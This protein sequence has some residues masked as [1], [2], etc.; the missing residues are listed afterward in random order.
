MGHELLFIHKC[1]S[2][3]SKFGFI[4]THHYEELQWIV[5]LDN[6]SIVIRKSHVER[7]I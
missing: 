3:V 4:C 7:S 2:S 6:V 5:E 1:T